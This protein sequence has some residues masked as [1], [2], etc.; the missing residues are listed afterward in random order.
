MEIIHRIRCTIAEWLM[1]ISSYI[2]P[3]DS[4]NKMLAV[5]LLSIYYGILSRDS[6]EWFDDIDKLVEKYKPTEEELR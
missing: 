1:E 2:M 3:K 5:G 6:D 4:V